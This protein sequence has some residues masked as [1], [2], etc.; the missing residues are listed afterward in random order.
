MYPQGA[1]DSFSDIRSHLIYGQ[2]I[3]TMIHETS[4]KEV[5]YE[6]SFQGSSKDFL[7]VLSEV[8]L[9]EKSEVSQKEKDKYRMTPLIS[10]I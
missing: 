9:K 6:K 7:N 8:S 10:G 2:N 5:I 3:V 4:S 1:C